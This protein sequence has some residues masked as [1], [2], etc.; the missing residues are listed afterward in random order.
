MSNNLNIVGVIHARGGS[1]R[2]PLKNI[3]KLNGV[4]LIVY[5]INAAKAS[6][7]LRRLIVSTDH[8]EIQKISLDAGAEVPFTRPPELSSDCPSEWVT[9][10]AIKYVEEEESKPVDLAITFQPTTPFMQTEDIDKCIGLLL[11]VIKM[12]EPGFVYKK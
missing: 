11:R 7:Y 12:T 10:H 3:K 8:E 9:Q 6:K 2:V 1:V 5:I 4:P